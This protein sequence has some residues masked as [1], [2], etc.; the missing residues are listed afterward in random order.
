MEADGA[1]EIFLNSIGIYYLKMH[2]LK[3]TR[4]VGDGDSSLFGC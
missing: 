3:Y 1:V 4:C 2:N